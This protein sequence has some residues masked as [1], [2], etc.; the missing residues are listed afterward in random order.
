MMDST[1]ASAAP[2][3]TDIESRISRAF[4]TLNQMAAS[5]AMI[6]RSCNQVLEGLE[7]D[8]HGALHRALALRAATKYAQ[9]T[10]EQTGDV[11]D[12]ITSVARYLG[13]L[14]KESCTCR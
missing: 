7:I 14:K 9:S 1:I 10:L 4:L 8:G 11:S 5:L 6:E 2:S 3:R 13:C 12:T